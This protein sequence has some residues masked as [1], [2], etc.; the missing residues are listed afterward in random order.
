M[1]RVSPARRIHAPQID[2]KA[3][4]V[5]L[6]EGEMVRL[7]LMERITS[8]T[9]QAGD[10][11]RLESAEDVYVNNRLVIAAG[12]PARGEILALRRK[13][14]IV[15]G[16]VVCRLGY[17][18]TVD[19]QWVP[20][21]GMVSRNPAGLR[22]VPE[23]GREGLLSSSGSETETDVASGLTAFFFLPFYP[24]FKGRDAVL[25]EGTLFEAFVA[26]D[27]AIR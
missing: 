2:G 18:R 10:Q 6:R 11:V 21:E 13:R 4:A 12:A 25:E 14:G 22:E 27:V 7:R 19:G 1:V 8:K 24:L 20:L 16:E 5:T 26:R 9:N 17:V 23:G 3:A 15:H